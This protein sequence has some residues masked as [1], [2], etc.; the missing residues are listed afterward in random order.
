MGMMGAIEEN[1]SECHVGR[2]LVFAKRVLNEG[3]VRESAVFRV[4]VSLFF[5]DADL[6]MSSATTSEDCLNALTSQLAFAE[7]LS[8]SCVLLDEETLLSLAQLREVLTATPYR[9]AKGEEHP[10]SLPGASS[11]LTTAM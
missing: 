8:P 9:S 3:V 6:L 2:E 4:D 10:I 1:L 5:D 7:L 11:P